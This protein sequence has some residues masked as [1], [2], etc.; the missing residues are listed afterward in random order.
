MP[1]AGSSNE[2]FYEDLGEGHPIFFIPGF[3]G[4]GSFWRGQIEFFKSRFRVIVIDQRGAGASARSQQEYSLDQMTDDVQIVMDAAKIDA[5]V[6]VGHSTGGAIAQ[7][8]AVRTPERI[9]GMLLSSTWC[10]PGNYFRRVFEFRR[11]LLELGA[12]DL[13]HKAGIFFRYPP[14]YAETHDAAFEN[15]GDV[16]V[17]IN[18]SR[19]NA[20]LHAD[21]NPVI[22]RIKVP[23]LVVAARDDTLVP[24]YM[25]EE[26]AQRI[27]HSKYI[28][29]DQGGHFLPETR[30]SDYNGLLAEFLSSLGL[31]RHSA[32]K[33]HQSAI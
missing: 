21:L 10:T 31:P 7:T 5:A 12:T 9:S 24:Q 30:S 23:T 2:L 14:H 27:A 6:L 26:V 1:Y 15:G 32:N 22:D 25:S 13:F 4:V 19:I 16:D 17:D 8:L 28:V 11:S 3:G 20:V 29:L 33:K 18:I